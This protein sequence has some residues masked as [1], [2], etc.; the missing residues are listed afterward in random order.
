M[1]KRPRDLKP[2]E[3]LIKE[4]QGRQ[5]MGDEQERPGERPPTPDPRRPGDSTEAGKR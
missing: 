1:A 2:G 5:R 4:R 3:K